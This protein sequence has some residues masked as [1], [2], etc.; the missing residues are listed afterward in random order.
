MFLGGCFEQ[1]T[2]YEG[3]YKG[4]SDPDRSGG[5]HRGGCLFFPGAEPCVGEQ[6]LRSWYR[7]L[8][9][10]AAAVVGYYNDSERGAFDYWLFHLR[11]RVRREDRL[12]QHFAAG[13][14][15]GF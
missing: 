9:L 7:A 15:R 5:H 8:E 14:L 10:C 2:E 1:K 3:S 4:D 12:H 6:Y 11:K 13:V